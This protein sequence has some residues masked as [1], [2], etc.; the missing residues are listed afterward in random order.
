MGACPIAAKQYSLQ[1]LSDG[2]GTSGASP[3]CG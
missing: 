1:Q 3:A 2:T